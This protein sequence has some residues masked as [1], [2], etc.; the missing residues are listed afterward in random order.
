VNDA[1]CRYFGKKQEELLGHR[2]KVVI[3]PEDREQV[4]RL[5]FSLSPQQPQVWI[6]QRIIMPEGS[7]RWQRWSDRAIFDKN[8]RIIEYQ[9]VGRDITEQKQAEEELQKLTRE[10]EQR[11]KD[12]TEA[13]V[14]LNEEML[15][16]IDQ[17]KDVE[18]QL[19]L[20]VS[21]KETL[22]KEIHHRVKNNLQIIASLL[23]LQSQYIKD[24]QTLSVIKDSQNRIK[25]MA[26]IHEKIYQSKS[27]DRIDYGDYLEKITRSL[28][29]SYGVSPKK[30]AMKIH[31]KNVMLHIDKAIPCSLIINELLANSFKHAFPK[32]R[33]G[34]VRIDV[35]HDGD[36]IRL[37]YSD[38]GIGLP[39]SITLDHTGSLGM[40]LISGLT[41]QLKG[42]VEIQ[43]G[44]GTTFLIAFNV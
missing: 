23:N 25:T 20:S 1:Y 26:L 13:L 15:A 14:H 36:T 16:E 42:T 12:R 28:F 22:L 5:F 34:E 19:Q 44:G 43:R 30:V 4:T 39:E 11:V 27:L 8:G 2:F 17:R 40:R 37:L 33:T 21:E 18:R 29:E 31:A 6:V 38:N 41:Q 24:E 32:D 10:L 7:I 3:H 9:S 35:R